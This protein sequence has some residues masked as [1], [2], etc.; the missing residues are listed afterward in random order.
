MATDVMRVRLHLRGILEPSRIRG[1]GG[2]LRVG[3]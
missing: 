2:W 3:E 1:G